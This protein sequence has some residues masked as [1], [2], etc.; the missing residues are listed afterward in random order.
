MK[1]T[2]IALAVPALLVASA[3]N[4]ATVYE[5][6]GQKFDVYGRAQTNIYNDVAAGSSDTTLEGSGRIGLRGTTAINDKVSGFA[7]GEWQIS[8]ENSDHIVSNECEVKPADDDHTAE[9]VKCDSTD[10]NELKTRHFYAGFDGGEVGKVTFGQTDTAYYDA[11]GVTDIFNEWGSSA[12]AYKG[13]QEGQVIYNNTFAGFRV[14]TSYQFSDDNASLEIGSDSQG[15]TIKVPNLDYGYAAN[16]GYTFAANNVGVN[17]GYA[18]DEYA[19]AGQ[20]A[21]K[22][23]WAL[24]TSYG[25]FGEQGLYLAALYNE[26]K[27]EGSNSYDATLKGYEIAATYFFANNWGL[28]SGYNFAEDKDSGVDSSDNYLLG[29]QYTFTSNFYTYAEYKLDQLEGKDDAWTLALQYNF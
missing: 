6:D 18:K 7:R 28:L 4:A 15:K 19:Q 5:K 3:A 25:V 23:D 12:N 17:A 21:S 26:S 29:A 14:G 8:S 22:T 10:N 13:R 20:T 24:S 1:K 9:W 11:I 16:V 27:I 2:L